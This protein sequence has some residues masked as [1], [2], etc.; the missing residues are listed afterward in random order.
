MIS[1]K[2][3]REARAIIAIYGRDALTMAR[4]TEANL[5]TAGSNRAHTWAEI[6]S[7]IATHNDRAGR[8]SGST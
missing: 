7:I 2:T 8:A 1:D 3:R 4:R 5:R 6:V